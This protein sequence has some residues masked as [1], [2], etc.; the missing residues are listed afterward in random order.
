MAVSRIYAGT[1][2]EYVNALRKNAEEVWAPELKARLG[3]LCGELEPL[4]RK[5]EGQPEKKEALVK[6]LGELQ[7]ALASCDAAGEK[8]IRCMS[9]YERA[10]QV[11]EECRRP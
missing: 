8:G 3:E 1:I 7:G 10:V 2:A 4:A 6:S 9:F 5:L 11:I